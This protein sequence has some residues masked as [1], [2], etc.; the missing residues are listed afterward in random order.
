MAAVGAAQDAAALTLHASCVAVAG[1]AVLIL[2]ASGRGKSALALE[3]MARGARLIADDG[4][5]LSPGAPPASPPMARAPARIRGRI[6]ARFVGILGAECA[7]PAPVALAVDL[8]HTETTRLPPRRSLCLLGHDVPLLHK[9]DAGY[10]PA[11]ILQYV[12]SGRV[13]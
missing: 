9:V 2:G 4:T 7:G 3:L 8:D 10:F 12:L 6:E 11:A 5:I 1:R 13:E